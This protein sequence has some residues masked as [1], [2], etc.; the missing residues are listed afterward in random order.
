M[1]FLWYWAGIGYHQYVTNT[2]TLVLVLLD[3]NPHIAHPWSPWLGWWTVVWC[4]V[5]RVGPSLMDHLVVA[6]CVDGFVL[7]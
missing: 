1:S 5:E 3:N 2:S 6:D 7:L 4:Q